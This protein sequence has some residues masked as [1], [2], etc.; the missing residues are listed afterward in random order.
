MCVCTHNHTTSKSKTL[1]EIC[2]LLGKYTTY[3]GNSLPTP[4]ERADILSRHVVR[5][6]I[7]GRVISQKSAD[8]LYFA[9]EV[10]N[11]G[12]AVC[13]QNMLLAP[14]LS[15]EF[16]MYS[17]SHQFCWVWLLFFWGNFLSWLVRHLVIL[18]HFIVKNFRVFFCNKNFCLYSAL[19]AL[20][21]IYSNQEK[22]L[23]FHRFLWF[24][25]FEVLCS[26]CW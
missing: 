18:I 17:F 2:V 20:H 9:V 22:S 6:T 11:H 26:V 5:I 4:K 13:P 14:T 10:S 16:P 1:Y 3:S 12:S 21:F 15:H 24:L 7:I 23:A 8:H 25:L 19:A